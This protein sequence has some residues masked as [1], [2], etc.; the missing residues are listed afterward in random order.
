MAFIWRLCLFSGGAI[1]WS[2]LLIQCT[3][4]R[5]F[6]Y[7]G[8]YKHT[9]KGGVGGR[10]GEGGRGPCSVSERRRNLSGSLC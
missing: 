6:S 4:P 3:H 7:L 1:V 9:Y 2:D 8:A 10:E 5:Y